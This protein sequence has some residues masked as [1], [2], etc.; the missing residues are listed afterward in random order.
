MFSKLL[1]SD[2]RN[3]IFA[4]RR[5][6][7]ITFFLFAAFAFL[8]LLE[9]R[10]IE[11]IKPELLTAPATL[12]DYFFYVFAGSST[13]AF[14]ST[15]I[16]GDLLHGRI[17]IQMP[18]SW[19][20]FIFWMLFM[21]LYYPYNELHGVGKHMLILSHRREGWWFSKCVWVMLTTVC[22]F[23]TA[24]LAVA[25]AALCFGASPDLSV[26]PYVTYD[27]ISDFDSLLPQNNGMLSVL[28]LLIPAGAALSMMQLVLSLVA[29]PMYSYLL[30][31]GYVLLSTYIP[32]GFFLS[33]FTVAARSASFVANGFT[34]TSGLLVSALVICASML[35]GYIIFSRMD[36][37]NKG[38]T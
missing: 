12:G 2:V 35:L 4:C 3:G 27:F 18:T 23:L 34:L 20:V 14:D 16:V 5:K 13:G 15:G 1:R 9:R 37:L 17:N 36:I 7:V 21:T 25:A 26:T 30:M 29:T 19:L 38:D 10:V 11:Y 6:Y 24:F 33:N 31:A 8:F 22:F 28:L 32:S